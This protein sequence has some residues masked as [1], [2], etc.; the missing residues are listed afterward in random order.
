MYY[1]CMYVCMY[2]Y[3]YVYMHNRNTYV[4]ISSIKAEATLEN[5]QKDIAGII[6]CTITITRSCLDNSR[7]GMG[8]TEDQEEMGRGCW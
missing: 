5:Q 1:V 6:I 8:M 4:Y 3:V 2:V 7:E